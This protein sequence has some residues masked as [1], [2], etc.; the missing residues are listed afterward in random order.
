MIEWTE[1]VILS[2]GAL[3]TI[4][5]GVVGYFLRILHQDIKSMSLKI[6]NLNMIQAVKAEALENLEKRVLR[7]ETK[8]FT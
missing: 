8:I 5:L 3:I 6:D 7:L 4:L 2:S 1:I